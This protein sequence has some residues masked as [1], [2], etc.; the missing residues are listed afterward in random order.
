MKFSYLIKF[1]PLLSTIF[2]IILLS[3]SNQKEYTKLRI[4]IWDTPSLSIGSYLAI[5]TGTG[6]LA[7]YFITTYFAKTIQ[8]SPIQSLKYNPEQQ[9]IYF[10]V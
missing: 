6:F 9:K 5:S 2:I 3:I 1:T 10:S 8:T 7:S 4:L